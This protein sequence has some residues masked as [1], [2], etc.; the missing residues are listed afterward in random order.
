MAKRAI[1]DASVVM[2][3]LLPGEP[4]RLAAH[5]ILEQFTEGVL[6]LVAPSLLLYEV[7]NS[8]LKAER[9]PE[10]HVSRT[11]TDALVEELNTLGIP[12]LPV[13]MDEIIAAARRYNCWAYDASYVALAE[14]E[15]S[16]LIT[17]DRRLYNSIRRGFPHI[18]WV[19]DF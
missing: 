9:K 3:A 1:V 19:E 11:I 18:R 17:A 10:R 15:K 13:S 7:A 6:E 16:L 12:M 14:R 5:R 4:T 2:A 8:L